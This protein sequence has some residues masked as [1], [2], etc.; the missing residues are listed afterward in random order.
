MKYP[1]TT[2][3]CFIKFKKS[4]PQISWWMVDSSLKVWTAFGVL[5]CI[6]CICPGLLRMTRLIRSHSQLNVPSGNI[7]TFL[8]LKSIAIIFLRPSYT[9]THTHNAHTETHAQGHMAISTSFCFSCHLIWLAFVWLAVLWTIGF[10]CALQLETKRYARFLMHT[11]YPSHILVSRWIHWLF[12]RQYCWFAVHFFWA[13]WFSEKIYTA[14]WYCR[15]TEAGTHMHRSPFYLAAAASWGCVMADTQLRGET[16][17]CL[18]DA[19][20]LTHRIHTHKC[21]RWLSLFRSRMQTHLAALCDWF[22][23]D[24]AGVTVS[25]A[26]LLMYPDEIITQPF[27]SSAGQPVS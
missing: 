4:V 26:S 22:R 16:H 20:M 23:T 24:G 7:S 15:S 1:S 3:L 25:D 6:H 9:Q 8:R 14:V 2:F 27:C 13:F 11:A 18:H 19:Y 17:G 21:R 5:M 12:Y 10:G